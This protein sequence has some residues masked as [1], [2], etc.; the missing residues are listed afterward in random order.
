VLVGVVGVEG[1]CVCV[2]IEGHDLVVGFEVYLVEDALVEQ[3]FVV[4]AG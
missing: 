1:V 2:F 3:L 4:G